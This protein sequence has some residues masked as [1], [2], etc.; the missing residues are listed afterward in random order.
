MVDAVGALS[1]LAEREPQPPALV[2]AGGRKGAAGK[3]AAGSGA[4][5]PGA[6][7]AGTAWSEVAGKEELQLA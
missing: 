7:I 3:A 4:T 1:L 2:D 6:A 5:G